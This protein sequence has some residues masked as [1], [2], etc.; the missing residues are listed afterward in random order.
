MGI[1][2]YSKK[3]YRERP[4]FGETA[5][6]VPGAGEGLESLLGGIRDWWQERKLPEKK[7]IARYQEEPR[8]RSFIPDPTELILGERTASKY[9]RWMNENI[10]RPVG[11]WASETVP[12]SFQKWNQSYQT[13]S[14][15]S[16]DVSRDWGGQIGD[17]GKWLVNTPATWGTFVA[18]VATDVGESSVAML[19]EWAG[20]EG[21]GLFS[22]EQ[23]YNWDAAAVDKFGIESI[24]KDNPYV[25]YDWTENWTKK[26]NPILD[27]VAD[28]TSRYMYEDFLTEGMADG[29]WNEIG[30][31]SLKGKTSNE[32]NG[33]FYDKFIEKYA[34][35]WNMNWEYETDRILK[36]DYDLGSKGTPGAIEEFEIGL[37]YDPLLPYSTDETGFLEG[38]TRGLG[39]ALLMFGGPGMLSK[40]RKFVPKWK[41]K[42]LDEGIMSVAKGTKYGDPEPWKAPEYLRIGGG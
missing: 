24:Y 25:K 34:N 9:N 36:K 41:K 32:Q 4:S 26:T 7:G 33:M 19:P 35:E 22:K 42:H 40:S 14:P 39:E 13:G 15:I 18:D 29:I 27:E 5:W 37:N 10:V 1:E 8:N 11:K 20:G 12:E 23:K 31:D 2:E 30:Y 6:G 38:S 16:E 3:K 28:S 21:R 17:V